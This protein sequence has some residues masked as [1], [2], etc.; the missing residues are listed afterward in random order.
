VIDTDPTPAHGIARPEWIADGGHEW[1]KVPLDTCKGLEI[2]SYS[3][4]HQGFAYL[5]GDCDA[6]VW[7]RHY[8]L[9]VEKVCA[10]NL[11]VTYID[12]DWEGRDRY[13]RYGR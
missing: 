2:S 8:G 7:F 13:Q 1:L 9:D 12:G 11:K 10:M 6:A 4:Q 5:E 3:Y